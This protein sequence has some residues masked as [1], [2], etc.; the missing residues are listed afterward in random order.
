MRKTLYA[1]AS[2][3]LLFPVFYVMYGIVLFD[4]VF[5]FSQALT[6]VGFFTMWVCLTICFGGL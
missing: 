4:C 3:L 6:A 2:I 5:T 1:I